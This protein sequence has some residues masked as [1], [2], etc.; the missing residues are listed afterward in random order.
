M[1]RPEDY[2]WHSTCTIPKGKS[3]TPMSKLKILILLLLVTLATNHLHAQQ[4]LITDL[5]YPY[6][7]K[8]IET[9]KRNYPEVKLRQS[10]VNIA[11]SSLSKA[12]VM[13]LDAFTASYIYS[14]KNSLNVITP[15]IFNGY[16]ASVS[17]N[18]GTLLSKPYNVRSARESLNVAQYEQREYNLSLEAQVKRLYFAYLGAQADLRVRSNSVLDGEIAVKQLKYSF[19]KGENTFQAYNEALTSLYNQ[20]SYKVQA[21]I[22]MLTAKANLE[23]ILGTKLEDIN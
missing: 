22:A 16:Q 18:L 19:E 21:E 8:L 13:W 10:Q 2:D 12:K 1:A 14:P 9:A 6:L 3:L 5:S 20:N 11:Q 17:I 23:E 4:T 7:D 15:T